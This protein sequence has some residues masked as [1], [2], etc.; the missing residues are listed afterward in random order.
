[1]GFEHTA[2]HILCVRPT[3]VVA[4]YTTQHVQNMYQVN[5]MY[6]YSICIH[7]HVYTCTS[8][9]SKGLM[10]DFISIL[11][12]TRYLRQARRLGERQDR[13]RGYNIDR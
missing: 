11:A 3:T 1:M 4:N 9:E 12:S 6:V 7:A 8:C 5:M 2:S 13:G 10:P